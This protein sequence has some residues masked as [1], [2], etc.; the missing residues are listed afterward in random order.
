[1]TDTIQ[2]MIAE[3]TVRQLANDFLDLD[4]RLQALAN[5]VQEMAAEVSEGTAAAKQASARVNT[6]TGYVLNVRDGQTAIIAKLDAVLAQNSAIA[7][8]LAEIKA[9]LPVAPEEPEVPEEPEQPE[10]PTDPEPEPEPEPEPQLLVPM[11]G[12]NFAG[13]G[14]NP[15]VD[16]AYVAK[17][18]THYRSILDKP[19]VDY[20]SMYKPQAGKWLARVPYAAERLFAVSGNSFVF[21]EGYL[22]ELKAV[23][24]A[25]NAAGATVV[26]D[27]HNYCRWWVKTPSTP[28]SWAQRQVRTVNGAVS[29]S[30]WI[31]IGHNLCPVDYPMLAR[32]YRQIAQQFKQFD[33]IYGLMNEPHGRGEK[34]GGFAVEAT[35]M[36][37]VQSLIDAVREIDTEHWVTVGGCG[38]STAK[39]WRSVSDPLKNV[40]G[41]KI[42]F[43]AHQYPD[44]QGNG[45][46]S[47]RT[48]V[49]HTIDPVARANDW[50]DFILW[51]AEVGRPGYAGEYGCPINYE[52]WT[53]DNFQ[54]TKEYDYVV[55]GGAEFLEQLNMLFDLYRIARTQ[56]LAGPGDSDKYANGMDTEAGLKPNALA[57]VA[58]I[59]VMAPAF[60]PIAY[61]A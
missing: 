12:V 6:L 51:C 11:A 43:E 59:G 17:L 22:A 40:T 32:M 34:D 26:L 38:Y 1:M 14:N 37:S 57:T 15:D 58:R 47:W 21:K 7:A 44:V 28:I 55:Q 23:V 29:D 16:S 25:L 18:G 33:V 2:G 10:E 48:S 8:T 45:G 19:S 42:M 13:L 5:D 50:K 52:K 53:Q 46:G 30:Q 36:N 35:W 49:V 56:W 9:S 24:S 27:M 20:I 61:A 39:H 31:P 60:G 41:E 54:G 3:E 4:Q